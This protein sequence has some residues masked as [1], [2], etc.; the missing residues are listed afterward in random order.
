MTRHGSYNQ[1]YHQHHSDSDKNLLTPPQQPQLGGKARLFLVVDCWNT[2][3][4]A[5]YGAR[6]V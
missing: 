5:E 4:P 3:P 1:L 2:R 6:P